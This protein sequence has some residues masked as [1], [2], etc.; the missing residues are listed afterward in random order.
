MRRTISSSVSISPPLRTES[1]R[2]KRLQ[3]PAAVTSAGLA[4]PMDRRRSML[5]T[6]KAKRS[7]AVLA[8]LAAVS[9][10]SPQAPDTMASLEE[11]REIFRHETFGDERFWTDVLRMN[12]VI[13][14][15]VDPVTALSVGLKVDADALPAG[16]LATADLT[17]PAT[18]VALLKLGAVVGVRGTVV[19]EGG[20]DRLTAVGVTCALCH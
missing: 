7:M 18:T 8:A 13:E 17:D 19:T 9:C 3:P 14:A 12:E 10:G 16:I 2:G 6:R 15:A 1:G 5:D 11:G 4:T 20:R